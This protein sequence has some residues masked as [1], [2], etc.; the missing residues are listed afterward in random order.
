M[1]D[2]THDLSHFTKNRNKDK[3]QK[4]RIEKNTTTARHSYS[5]CET[6]EDYNAAESKQE[7]VF[8]FGV[9]YRDID[10]CSNRNL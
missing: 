6:E 7:I 2:A 9:F 3:K 8:I 5:S 1:C 10:Y 4:E